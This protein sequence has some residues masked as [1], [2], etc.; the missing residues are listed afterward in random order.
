MRV[1][2]RKILIRGFLVLKGEGMSSILD[3]IGYR[4]MMDDE[5]PIEFNSVIIDRWH[6]R[7][8]KRSSLRW[9]VMRDR[10]LRKD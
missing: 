5:D 1:V 4:Y 9:N 7:D 6:N 3:D 8:R 2:I 10:V